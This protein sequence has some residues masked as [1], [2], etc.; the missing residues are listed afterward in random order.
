M[1]VQDAIR[2]NSVE[3]FDLIMNKNAH[4][5]ICGDVQMAFDVTVALEDILKVEGN[6][7]KEKAKDFIKDLKVFLFLFFLLS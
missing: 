7:D 5:Y 4:L 6:I 3:V 1:Y 2:K